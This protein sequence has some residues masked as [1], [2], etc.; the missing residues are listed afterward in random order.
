MDNPTKKRGSGKTTLKKEDYIRAILECKGNV[1]AVSER[2]RRD[3]Q[4][5]YNMINKHPEVKAALD[6]VRERQ[7]DNA[8]SKLHDLI[9]EHHPTAIIFYLKTI[10]RNRGYQDRQEIDGT[11]KL[12]V[13]DETE[14][15]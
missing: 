12:V 14:D 3:R 11:M 4:Q 8:E 2:L 1:T 7:L 9:N 5:V 6:E 10:G 13:V 15:A